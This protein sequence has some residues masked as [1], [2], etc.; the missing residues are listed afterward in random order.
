[1]ILTLFLMVANSSATAIM[2]YL[3][4]PIMNT[5]F[6]KTQHPHLVYH[7]LLAFIVPIAIIVAMIRYSAS[8]GQNYYMGYL[9]QRVVQ[10][11]RNDLF[12]HFLTLPMSFFSQQRTGG[13]ASRITNDVL[14]LSNSVREIV[15]TPLSASLTSG[16]LIGLIIYLDW[17]L[18]IV[19]LVVFPLAFFPI[20][21]F[22]KKIRVASGKSQE[23]FS[24]LNAQIH[25][26]L[27]GIR[28]VK[29]F[30]MEK[31]E[32][33][34]FESTNQEFFSMTMRS[35]R[36]MVAS[37][38]I[39]E[40]IG[41]IAFLVLLGWLARRVLFEGNLTIGDFIAVIGA[42]GT[43]YPNL[44]TFNGLWGDIQSALAA[45]DRCFQILDIQPDY[46]DVA[47]R[48]Q[49]SPLKKA[50]IFE[51]VNFEYIPGTPVLHDISFTLKRGEVL[52]LVGHSGSGKSTL[53][54]LIPRFYSP[55]QG[56]ILWDGVDLATAQ[57][58][59]LRSQISI[60]AQETILFHASIF[61][62]IAYG[63]MEA[64]NQEVEEAAQHAYAKKFI[65]ST[66]EKFNTI[67]GDR[68]I[69]LSGGERQRLA[70]ARALLKNPPLLILDEATSALDTE[71]EQLV[72]KA[73]NQLML[74][75]TTLVIA[76]RLSTI[77]RANRIL[78]L[79][80]GRLVAQGRHADLLKKRGLY[81]KL[82]HLQFR[83][84]SHSRIKNYD[85]H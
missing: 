71:S 39:V 5:T 59:S 67:V 83:T 13:L 56:R 48:V 8:Y 63:K 32:N 76:H 14:I 70:I 35:I 36:A 74:D 81:S 57:I 20:Y 30:G 37:S 53:A 31:H 52:A 1:M 29:A 68:G 10:K 60:V 49:I 85:D 80:K 4:K 22:G 79:D 84:K 38:P 34:K 27:S 17:R 7:H 75:R 18:A 41:T 51:H 72:Q 28:V 69:K 24:N 55:T 58:D 78:V 33:K 66:P 26:V 43:L 25:E 47:G 2:M 42:V 82:Y 45:A 9:S 61:N 16:A 21:R 3:L 19:V 44:K 46:H 40:M 23:I 6:V 15:G 62:N 77:R 64:S 11:I 73:L 65:L 50:L 12:S 54:D